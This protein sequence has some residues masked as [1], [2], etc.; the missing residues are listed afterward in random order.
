MANLI[1]Y[2]EV[3][4]AIAAILTLHPQFEK[5]FNKFERLA[6]QPCQ[7]GLMK[8]TDG[9][10]MMVAERLRVTGKI[11]IRFCTSAEIED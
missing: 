11:E 7:A 10:A 2:Q 8:K 6:W 5:V 3:S 4:S 1:T 9:G